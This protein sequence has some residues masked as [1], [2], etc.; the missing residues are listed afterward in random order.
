MSHCVG[1]PKLRV[2]LTHH[3]CSIIGPRLEGQDLPLICKKVVFSLS[4]LIVCLL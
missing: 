4:S 3:G 1:G 2:K